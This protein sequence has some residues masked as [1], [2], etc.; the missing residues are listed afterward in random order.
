MCSLI[1]LPVPAKD[2]GQLG[3]RPFVSCRQLRAGRQH[4][5]TQLQRAVAQIE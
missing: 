3:A 1:A 5:A 4:V 2:I